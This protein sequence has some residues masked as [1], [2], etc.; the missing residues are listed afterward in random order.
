MIE[1]KPIA[2]G[3]GGNAYIVTDGESSLLLECGINIKDI[4]IATGFG[5]TDFEAA[6]VTH[7]HQDHAKATKDVLRAGLPVYATRGTIEALGIKHHRLKRIVAGKQLK[8]GPWTVLPFE[9]EHDAAEP[10]GLL[11]Q[12]EQGE[13]LLFATD[14]YFLRYRFKGLTHIAVECN[15]STEA[16]DD[17]ILQGETPFVLRGR[18]ERSH[19]SLETFKDFLDA[20]DL[21]AA[22]EIWLLHMS[23]SNSDQ[24]HF[25]NEIREKTGLPVY[26]A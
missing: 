8:V 22:Q 25:E 6:F 26:T 19:M 23:S 13:K 16:L 14:T 20:N 17:A 7:E 3:S 15:Y 11:V 10:I 4:R 1:F 2:S 9:T 18:L 21:S 12:H 24:K 5:L